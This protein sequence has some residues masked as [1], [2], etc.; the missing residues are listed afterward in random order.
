MCVAASVLTTAGLAL[1]YQRF[2]HS[3][4]EQLERY[5]PRLIDQT[6]SFL[7]ISGELIF[8]RLLWPVSVGAGEGA[9]LEHCAMALG[10]R[11]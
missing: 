8:I 5:P 1:L 3:S 6:V 4:Y 9:C 11:G 2:A 10:Q 7:G